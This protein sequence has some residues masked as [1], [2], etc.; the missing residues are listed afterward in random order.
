MSTEYELVGACILF[1]RAVCE[2]LG[3]TLDS[4]YTEY[5]MLTF[6]KDGT[7]DTGLLFLENP[8]T[9]TKRY[10]PSHLINEHFNINEAKERFPELFL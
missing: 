8:L 1:S 7:Y 3:Y 6:S 4:D 5:P 10:I 2:T 9:G